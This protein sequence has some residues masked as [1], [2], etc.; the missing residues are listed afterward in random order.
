[1]RKA[2]ASVARRRT[3]CPSSAGV[4]AAP[5]VLCR[6]GWFATALAGFQRGGFRAGR[7]VAI[8]G[9][10]GLLG[11]CAALVAGALGAAEV[12]LV[13]R[14]PEQ[15]VEIAALDP[16][17][18][19]E[20]ADDNTPVDFVLDCAGGSAVEGTKALIARLARFGAIAFVGALA[21]ALPVPTSVLMR[22]SQRLV[23]SFW[24]DRTQTRETLALI[25]SGAIDLSPFKATTFGL[26]QITDAMSHSIAHSGG[27]RHVA[28][29]P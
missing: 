26:H 25:A 1:M 28:L 22:N 21:D 10:S 18:V 23:G 13:G 16:R 2:G 19:V 3:L 5:E 14:R 17:I 6:L 27:L 29:K 12:R 11:S 15:M 9:G 8:H 20:A 7:T 4:T 24:F